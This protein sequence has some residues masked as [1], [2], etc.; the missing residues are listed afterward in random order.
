MKLLRTTK[1]QQ[2]LIFYHDIVTTFATPSWFRCIENDNKIYLY[3]EDPAD[4]P[5]FVE[6]GED[7]VR[8]LPMSMNDM[9]KKFIYIHR[10]DLTISI[11]I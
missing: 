9:E 1:K 7:T 5:L 2:K 6:I 8:Q 4:N 3:M 10:D 11:N